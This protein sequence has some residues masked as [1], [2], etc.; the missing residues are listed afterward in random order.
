MTNTA[1]SKAAGVSSLAALTDV[2]VEVIETTRFRYDNEA[3]FRDQLAA[4]LT[5][6]GLTVKIEVPCGN[7]R[8]DLAIAATNNSPARIGIECKV[9][10][11]TASLR[12]QIFRYAATDDHDTIVVATT[13]AAHRQLQNPQAAIPILVALAWTG[14]L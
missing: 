13:R 5:Q 2:V 8:I 14:A 1:R 9:A 12:R 3:D 4:A 11:S 7:G 10:G 6:E